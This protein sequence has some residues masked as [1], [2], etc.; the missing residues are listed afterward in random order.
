MCHDLGRLLYSMLT[1][2]NR[3]QNFG[4]S[5]KHDTDKNAAP[6]HHVGN[7]FKQNPS[8]ETVI[9]VVPVIVKGYILIPSSQH[10]YKHI[11]FHAVELSY[12]P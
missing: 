12:I 9:T 6:L 10:V 1:H 2:I 5:D 7:S 8:G 3:R 11:Y 4:W